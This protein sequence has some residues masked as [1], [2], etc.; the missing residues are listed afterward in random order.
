MFTKES[1]WLAREGGPG[2]YSYVMM[3]AMA[4]RIDDVS[5]VY[6]T[7][8]SGADKRKYQSSA[9]LAFIREFTG[10]RWIPRTKSQQRGKFDDVI[11][12]CHLWGHSL[13]YI[14]RSPLSWYM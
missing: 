8:W 10:D 13:I 1:T 9:S 2:H 12:G 3:S 5:I 6:L 7:A 4:S 14:P 11:V